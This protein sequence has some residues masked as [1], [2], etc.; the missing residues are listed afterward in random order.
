MSTLTF[1]T[2]PQSRGAIARWMLEECGADYNTVVLEYGGSI[3]QKPYIDMNPMGKVPALTDGDAIITEVA[4]VCAYLADKFSDKGLAPALSSPLRGEY[5]RW[6][7]FLAGPLEQMINDKSRDIEVPNDEWRSRLGY[8][9]SNDVITTLETLLENKTYI[10][11]NSFTAVDLVMTAS[12][13]FYMEFGLF[14]KKAVFEQYV[15]KHIA[16]PAFERAKELDEAL[17]K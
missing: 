14:P 2:N 11:G 5:Y 8:G 9:C 10:V 16:R 3:K 1:Y 15:A 4:A 17:A 13:R 12:L 7:F 6:F